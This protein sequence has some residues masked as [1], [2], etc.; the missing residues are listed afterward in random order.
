M[1]QETYHIFGWNERIVDGNDL[2]FGAFQ[3]QAEDNA[4]DTTI[5]KS[6]SFTRNKGI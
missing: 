3:Q 2:N 4:A 5:T 1:P 6:W